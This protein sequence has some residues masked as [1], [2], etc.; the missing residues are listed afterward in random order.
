MLG[1]SFLFVNN[2]I[3]LTKT[4]ASQ[5][6]PVHYST[7]IDSI[8]AVMFQFFFSYDFSVFFWYF[9]VRFAKDSSMLLVYKL[10]KK[11]HENQILFIV[12]GRVH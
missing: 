1:T 5:I 3:K 7:N 6:I 4:S 8:F 10:K 12:L 11:T 2:K 9:L